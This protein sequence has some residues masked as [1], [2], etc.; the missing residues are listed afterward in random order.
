M[1]FLSPFYWIPSTVVNRLDIAVQVFIIN[2]K[3]VYDND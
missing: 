1:I 3:Q 2:K